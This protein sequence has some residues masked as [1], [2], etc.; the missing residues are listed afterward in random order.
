MNKSTMIK[1]LNAG[2]FNRVPCEMLLYVYSK[3]KKLPG[4]VKRRYAE[5]TLFNGGPF[6]C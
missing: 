3:K 1:K 4:L 5:A 6:N 2:A